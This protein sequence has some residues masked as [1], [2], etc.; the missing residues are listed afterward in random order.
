[1]SW[2]LSRYNSAMAKFRGTVKYS[3][4]EGGH[5][6]LVADDGTAY[7]LE[8]ADPL[9]RKSGARVEVDGTIDRAALS[10]TMTGPRLKVKSV[11]AI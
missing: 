10:F 3:D 4:L 2:E 7:E 8:G 6:Q 1:L 5:Y 9:L 11:R